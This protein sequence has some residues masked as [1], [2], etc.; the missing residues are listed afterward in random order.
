MFLFPIAAFGQADSCFEATPFQFFQ[1]TNYNPTVTTDA[2]VCYQFNTAG[3]S[4]DFDFGYFA[5]CP[6]LAVTYTL[7]SGACDSIT[8]NSTG[9]FDISPEVI[10]VV[11]GKVAC[12]DTGSLGIAQ[13]CTTEI[14]TLPVELIGMTAYPTD[15]GV[16][17]TWSTASEAGS[18][19]FEVF[20]MMTTGDRG[21]LLTSLRAA[22]YSS[23]RREY[24][25]TDTDPEVGLTFYRLEGTDID[26]ANAV[27]MIL[28]V[29]WSTPDRSSLG[30][31]DLLGR[32][33]R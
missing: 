13:I 24:R 6:D 31:F 20:R 17:I 18:A 12:T 28:P 27:L 7:Y 30:P 23:G 5:F 16:V 10:Y 19:T 1:C 3:S 2:T 21:M 33:V 8:T 11:C 15:A 4:V 9:Y 26:G 14:L 32:R 25:W 29:Y 22:G